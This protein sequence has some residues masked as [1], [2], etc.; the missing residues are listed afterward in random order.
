MRTALRDS[1]IPLFTSFV[2]VFLALVSA[3]A[4]SPPQASSSV[5]N[6]Y[7]SPGGSDSGNGSWTNPFAD[8]QQLI[9]SLEPGE[10]GCL[11]A[12]T[13]TDLDNNVKFESG[14]ES[15]EKRITLQ[16]APGEPATINA[17]LYIPDGSDYITIRNLVLDGSRAPEC[18]AGDM[19]DILPSVVVNGDYAVFEYNEVTNRNKA[20]CFNVGASGEMSNGTLIKHNKIHGCGR[21]PR[22]NHDHGIYLNHSR[23]M[24]ITGNWIYSNADRGIQLRIDA[25]HTLIEH[26]VIDS[27]GVGILFSGDYGTASDYNIVRNNVITF[28]NQRHDV[29]SWYPEGNPKGVGNVV[30]GNCVFG[31]TR[32]EIGLSNG[33][34]EAYRNVTQ[35][36]LY[37][38]KL[39]NY[40][41]AQNDSCPEVWDGDS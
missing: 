23:N 17:R 33:G 2:L 1:R 32:G 10:T 34:F 11:K 15:D 37:E 26:N 25:D 35:D 27:N 14:G 28:S 41:S 8:V 12:G 22:T 6:F 38:R 3:I 29:E 7:A 5:C 39:D 30:N 19:C 21:L 18:N 4:F 20:I 40:Y 24:L 9:D 16:A 13:Y 31:G 36:P